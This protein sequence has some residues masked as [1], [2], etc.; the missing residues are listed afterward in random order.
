MASF[1]N[2]HNTLSSQC[3]TFLNDETFTDCVLVADGRF[4][5]C[6]K[7]VLAASST[8]FKVKRYK[9]KLRFWDL[10]FF[11]S[12]SKEILALLSDKQPAIVLKDISYQ[13][14]QQIMT[15]IYCGSVDIAQKEV[16]TFR[17]ILESLKIEFEQGSDGDDSEPEIIEPEFE[18]TIDVE[19]PSFESSAI[20]PDVSIK[21]EPKDNEY[22]DMKE[23]VAPEI[24]AL[25]DNHEAKTQDER[26]RI[27]QFRKILNF[28]SRFA[29]P[30]QKIIRI[31]PSPDGKIS[32]E[33]VVPNKKLLK[34]MNENPSL[35]PFCRKQFKTTKHRN[36]HVKYCFD[37][38]H[39]IVSNCPICGKSVC[40][41][42]YLRKHLKNVHGHEATSSS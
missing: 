40:D 35:C 38:P 2:V 1:R 34:F 23:E 39:R 12:N 21:E 4:L 30:V 3:F 17:G 11:I 14:L 16:E 13:N 20:Y 42:Y 5:N 6:H 9:V 36:E 10:I 31:Q 41:P 32:I 28:P 29:K 19:E 18:E 7:L 25:D 24:E 22:E 8:Y 15:Y 26:I 27:Q 37:N 33:R